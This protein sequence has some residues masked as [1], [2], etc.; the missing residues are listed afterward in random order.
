MLSGKLLRQEGHYD[1]ILGFSEYNLE[2]MLKGNPAIILG[3]KLQL[4]CT[5]ILSAGTE[6]PGELAA[7]T[8]EHESVVV[9]VL[10][11]AVLFQLRSSGPII[12]DSPEESFAKKL[13]LFYGKT[14]DDLMQTA[15][16]WGLMQPGRCQITGFETLP[17]SERPH[18]NN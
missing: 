10:V 14:N 17:P 12:I 1:L 2:M 5:L 16:S 11:P 4:D 13:L 3:E 18:F 15:Q 9:I 6:G 8:K 7:A